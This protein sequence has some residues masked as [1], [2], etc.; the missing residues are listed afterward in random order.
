MGQEAR[1]G[2]DDE[3]KAVKEIGEFNEE[4]LKLKIIELLKKKMV[5]S[6]WILNGRFMRLSKWRIELFLE[7]KSEF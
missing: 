7:M 2:S 4:N 5:G 6:G 3:E 1:K